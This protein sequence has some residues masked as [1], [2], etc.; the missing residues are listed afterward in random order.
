MCNRIVKCTD[1]CTD[2]L[3][4]LIDDLYFF[5]IGTFLRTPFIKFIGQSM[6]FFIFLTLIVTFSFTETP[7]SGTL[8]HAKNHLVLDAFHQHFND[9]RHNLTGIYKQL[10]ILQLRQFRPGIFQV[11]ICLWIVGKST[12]LEN[13]FFL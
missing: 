13:L 2:H 12:N 7:S 9:T 8:S 5:Q 3:H 10:H 6:S 11:L 4:L 1:H